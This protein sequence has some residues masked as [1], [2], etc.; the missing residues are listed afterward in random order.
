MNEAQHGYHA[1][2]H[3]AAAKRASLIIQHSDAGS[4]FLDIGCNAGDVSLELLRIN[5]AK[6]V[7][8]MDLDRA[9]VDTSLMSHER[10]T[11]QEGDIAE[12]NSVP[13]SDY[14]I[15]SAVHH[16]VL[17]NHGLTAAIRCIHLIARSTE[18]A[19]FFETGRINE[20]SYW[21]WQPALRR[22]FRTDEEHH[23]YLLCCLEGALAQVE[24]IGKVSIHGIKRWFLKF[25][26]KP[27]E[28]RTPEFKMGL[29]AQATTS[30]QTR[31]RRFGSRH[32][33]L[34]AMPEQGNRE[35][36]CEFICIETADKPVFIKRHVHRPYYS[37]LEYEVGL[38]IE[39][40]WAVRPIELVPGTA[41]IRFPLVRDESRVDPESLSSADRSKLVRD[42]SHIF[43]DA[44]AIKIRFGPDS[45]RFG[46]TRGCMLDFCDLNP[47]N[48]LYARRNGYIKV[49]IVDFEPQGARLR[50]RN[51]LNQAAL[52]RGLGRARVRESLYSVAG[53][54]T[55]FFE[56]S[57]AHLRSMPARF[58][59]GIPT[60]GSL[61]CAEVASI[62]GWRLRRLVDFVRTR[63]R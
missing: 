59:T 49:H 9:V 27:L 17:Y 54:L 26:L 8:G 23:T 47:N 25:S 61:V 56:V 36:P 48:V 1:K 19:I 45:W 60:L 58:K 43:R 46:N 13:V 57:L 3:T 34:F 30:D 40:P 39:R 33:G 37:R 21:P 2:H 22:Y 16:H 4:C 11:F 51:R 53:Y 7:H 12:A 41:E 14:S 24:V 28:Q 29:S 62:A 6:H 52:L 42:L 50:Y 35:S 32:A 38:Q 20:S 44:R 55:F 15:Y 31:L 10:F 18:R 63:A 5:N